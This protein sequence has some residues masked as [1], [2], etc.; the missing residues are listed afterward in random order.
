V[1]LTLAKNPKLQQ[2]WQIP[3]PKEALSHPYL[4]HCILAVSAL[5]IINMSS[6]GNKA[7][8]EAAVRHQ[9]AALSAFRPLLTNVTEKNCH[10]LCAS[11]VL[12][13]IFVA[14]VRES[15]GTAGNTYP[16]EKLLGICELTRGAYIIVRAA[17]QWIKNGSVSSLIDVKPWENAPELRPDILNAIKDIEE[18]IKLTVK[19]EEMI[20]IYSSALLILV[21]TFEATAVN[22]DHP[23]IVFLWLV[24]IQRQFMDLLKVKDNMALVLLAHYGV[25]LQASAEHWWCGDLGYQIVEM[26]SNIFDDDWKRRIEWPARIVELNK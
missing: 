23:T 12:T 16:L 11:S 24:L 25:V 15:P 26:V 20:A 6:H 21:Q 7:Y 8:R 17:E 4:M 14:G 9:D 10:A 22:T 3:V 2:M 18:S 5:H 19:S 13:V 1:H